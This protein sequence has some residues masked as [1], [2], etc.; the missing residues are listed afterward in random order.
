MEVGEKIKSARLIKGL[1]QEELGAL[2]GVQKSA[3]A[4]WESGRVVNIKRS[5]I[6]KLSEI[7]GIPAHELISSEWKNPS[8]EMAEIHSAVLTDT[9]LLTAL[10]EYYSLNE[11]SKKMVRNF[12]HNLSISK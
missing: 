9:E 12:I 8:V 1:T 2:L 5:R 6:K 7:L 3:I 11:Q 4:K 10:K